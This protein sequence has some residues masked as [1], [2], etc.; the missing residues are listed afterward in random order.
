M[1][2]GFALMKNKKVIKL[3][4]GVNLGVRNIAKTLRNTDYDWALFHTRLA[5]MGDI[6]NQNCH[7][8]KQ[9][10]IIMAMNG[11]ERTVSFLSKIKEITDTEAILETINKYNLSLGALKNFSSIFMGFF[12][13]KPFVVAD[14]TYNI[15]ILNNKKNYIKFIIVFVLLLSFRNNMLYALI[16]FIPLILIILK[17]NKKKINDIENENMNLSNI[18]TSLSPLPQRRHEKP[19]VSSD[20]EE[21]AKM[22][23]NFK[24]VSDKETEVLNKYDNNL[25]RTRKKNG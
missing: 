9:N 10:N 14:N 4:K 19:V 23:E 16:L 24:Y 2:I 15:K 21:I 11:T 6:C 3:E 13:E 7:P 12:N 22:I 17:E 8:F 1:E 5:S 20:S 25:T 18:I